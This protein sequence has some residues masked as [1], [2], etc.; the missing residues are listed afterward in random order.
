MH[1]ALRG[2]ASGTAVLAGHQ[3]SG[4]GR[5]GRSW[6][7]PPW[8]SLL[9]SF[10]THSARDPQSLGALSLLLGVAVADTVKNI[11]G[12]APSIKWPND[13]LVNG[14][15]VAGVLVLNKAIAGLAGPC[16]ITGIGLNVNTTASDLPETGTS[17]AIESGKEPSLDDVLG[18]LLGNLSEIVNRF[19]QNK[20]APL[21][22]R[23]NELLAFRGDIVFVEDG[24]RVL[25]GRVQG[26]DSL[27]A[28]ILETAAGDTLRVVAGELT[29]GPRQLG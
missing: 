18:I 14:R 15:K 21:I 8:S 5:S 19:E 13:V 9:L 26:V 6:D 27:G 23:V 2:A 1:L 29:R 17:L 10:I 25:E 22:A 24:A 12:Q 3:T 7:A 4:R 28:L 20:T 16:L 11:T